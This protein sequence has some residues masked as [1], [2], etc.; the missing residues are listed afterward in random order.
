[1]PITYEP[2]QTYTLASPGTITFTSIPSTYTDLRLIINYTQ[3]SSSSAQGYINNDSAGT[4]YS[5]TL[6]YG[7]G[8]SALSARNS[9]VSVFTLPVVS[10]STIP[11]FVTMDFM[12]YSNTSTF[13]TFLAQ[14][15]SDQNGSGFSA[16]SVFLWRDTSAIN[17]IDL[18]GNGT[19]AIGSTFTLYGVKNA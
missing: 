2:I 13:K 10:N 9:N 4:S 17:R 8:T 6:L 11:N 7:N 16:A 1:M 12:S 18:Y 3:G 14:G 15:S 19:F 5:R